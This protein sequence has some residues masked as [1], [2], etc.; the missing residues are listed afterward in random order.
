MAEQT[1]Y[2]CDG[3]PV[4]YVADD[5]KPIYMWN[6]RAVGCLNDGKVFGCNGRHLGWV[7]DGIIYDLGGNQVGY[8][9]DTCPVPLYATTAKDRQQPRKPKRPQNAPSVRP[10]LTTRGSDQSLSAF[11]RSGGN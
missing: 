6:G 11:L 1:L 5:A 7:D 10:A 3:Q 9:R 8:T 2:D 4:A